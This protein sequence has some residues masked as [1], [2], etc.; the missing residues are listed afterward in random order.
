MVPSNYASFF[1]AASQAA[2]ALIGLL[3]VVIA[4]RPEAIVGLA[5]TPHREGLPGA[6]SQVS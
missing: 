6:A 1:D 3:F 5:L 4:L 2:G